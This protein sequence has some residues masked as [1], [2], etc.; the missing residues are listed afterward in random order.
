MLDALKRMFARGPGVQE[1]PT[2]GT[3]LPEDRK[4]GAERYRADGNAK[5]AAGELLDAERCYAQAVAL[6]PDDAALHVNLGY[7]RLE[8][9][10]HSLALESFS[11]AAA[12]DPSLADATY[13]AGRA[14]QE[15]GELAQA[16][17]S[18]RDAVA[19]NAE[20][21]HAWLDLGRVRLALGDPESALQAFG[22]AVRAEPQLWP[23]RVQLTTVLLDVGRG[24]EALRSANDLVAGAPDLAAAHVCQGRALRHCGRPDDALA[25]FDR[26][27]ALGAGADALYGRSVALVELGRFAQA[28]ES[29]DAAA[30]QWAAASGERAALL[31]VRS[32]ALSGLWRY[33][34]A[35]ASARASVDMDSTQPES[36]CVLAHVLQMLGRSADALATYAQAKQRHPDDAQIR[37]D[38]SL[39][40]L[41]LGDFAQGWSGHEWRLRSPMYSPA[42]A[43]TPSTAP[44]WTGRESIAGKRLLLYSEQGL[45]DA[46]QFVRYVELVVRA[47][48][49]AIVQ[50]PKSLVRL[51]NQLSIGDRASLGVIG[52]GERAAAHDFQCSL[53]SLPAA[54]GTTLDTIPSRV[55]YLACDPSTSAAYRVRMGDSVAGP[56]RRRIGLVWGGNPRHRNDH[57][58]SLPL[59]RLLQALPRECEVVTLQPDVASSDL[60][61]VDRAGLAHHDLGST[62][63]DFADTAALIEAVDLVVTVDTSV[64][65]LAGALGRSVWILLP[66]Q[67]DWRWMLG[68]ED[69]PW[70]P[71]CRL[72]RQTAPGQWDEALVRLQAAL[73]DWRPGA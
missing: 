3:T 2:A 14:F 72:F 22:E 49:Q 46:I 25:C 54:F 1:Q 51:I 66:H 61:L 15:L 56:S 60:A 33:E 67:P 11:R 65:H 31:Q 32:V 23:A 63:R 47:G 24:Q 42:N 64:A 57:N 21:A 40:R 36:W 5:L 71:T 39:C 17:R 62:V 8:R 35:L 27:L 55:P 44:R 13:L 43:A 20:F 53:L 30:A 6:D 73:Q 26:A 4:A 34:E 70:Y 37:W 50:V 12:M 48:A 41:L 9:G 18:F 29:L 19:I 7:V 58:R 28:L 52:V 59:A 10:L 68:R 38:E 16:D 69:S 45:G